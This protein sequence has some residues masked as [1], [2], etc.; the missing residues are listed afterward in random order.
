MR[1]WARRRRAGREATCPEV[2]EVL[3]SYL[4]GHVDDITAQRVHR[5]LEHCRRCGLEV[6]T[7]EAIKDAVAH[8]TRQVD[9]EAVERL[10]QFG[11][12]LAEQG[13][14]EESGSPA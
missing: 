12:R 4:D 7:Y 9:P 8:R 2:A 3:Q 10:R 14:A 13:P 6:D 5:H 11:E 1:K